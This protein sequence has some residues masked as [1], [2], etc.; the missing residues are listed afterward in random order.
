[1]GVHLELEESKAGAADN[2]EGVSE[3][4]DI[5]TLSTNLPHRVLEAFDTGGCSVV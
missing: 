2:K 3:V 4:N 1:M 5:I